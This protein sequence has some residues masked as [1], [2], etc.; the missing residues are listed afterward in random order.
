VELETGRTHQIRVHSSH[1]GHPVVGDAKYGP[2]REG[3]LHLHAWT[4]SFAHPLDGTQLD[5]RSTLPEWAR[6]TDD[7]DAGA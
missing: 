6:S 2:D 1:L 7:P 5:L 3:P 4:L